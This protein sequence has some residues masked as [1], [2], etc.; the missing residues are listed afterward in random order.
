[1]DFGNEAVD[2]R[3]KDTIAGLLQRPRSF[4]RERNAFWNITQRRQCPAPIDLAHC[5]R[6]WKAVSLRQLEKLRRVGHDAGNIATG[7]LRFDDEPKPMNKG[8]LVIKPSSQRQRP[9]RA[10]ARPL[11]MT[12]RRTEL[13]SD[14]QSA[15]RRIVSKVQKTMMGVTVLVIKCQTRIDVLHG[16]LQCPP[17]PT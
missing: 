6:L 2:A 7:Y 16:I 3:K 14:R 12:A 17:P 4:L 9:I 11:R 8:R 10:V 15:D 5:P 1:M 13:R